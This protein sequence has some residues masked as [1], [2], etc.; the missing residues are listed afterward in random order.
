MMVSSITMLIPE[1]TGDSDKTV[2]QKG[3]NALRKLLEIEEYHKEIARRRKELHEVPKKRPIREFHMPRLNFEAP[4]YWSMV[5]LTEKEIVGPYNPPKIMVFPIFTINYKGP[6][7]YQQVTMPPLLSHMSAAQIDELI[8][9][10]LTSD[11]ECHTQSVERGVATTAQS[12]KRRRTDDSQLRMAL[13]T[14]AAREE[15]KENVTVKR[16][17]VHFR[18]FL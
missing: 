17:K 18:Q 6:T 15:L 16:F 8:D 4:N 5:K 12:V 11:F 13:S 2:R 14:V 7:K 10:P 1:I 3:R 9:T